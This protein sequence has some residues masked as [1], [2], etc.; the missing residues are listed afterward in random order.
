M[1][2]YALI[3]ERRLKEF[4]IDAKD[5]KEAEEKLVSMY[6]E[7]RINMSDALSY[8]IQVAIEYDEADLDVPGWNEYALDTYNKEVPIEEVK[9]W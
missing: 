7:G 8:C 2:F 3:E 5:E 1:K 9:E 6:K 4:V